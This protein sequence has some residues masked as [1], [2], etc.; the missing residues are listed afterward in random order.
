[1]IVRQ[2]SPHSSLKEGGL[3]FDGND[4]ELPFK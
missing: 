2:P 4:E 1:M 3:Q